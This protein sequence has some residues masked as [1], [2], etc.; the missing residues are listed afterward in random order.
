MAFDHVT[1][2]V[3]GF[4]N[5]LCKWCKTGRRNRIC[6]PEKRFLSYD[7]AKEGISFLAERR[8]I[9]R[10]S[11][12]D[13]FSWGEPFL[14]PQ[15]NDIIGLL[16]ENEMRI[17]LSTNASKYVTIPPEYLPQIEY[18]IISIS[19][20]SQGTYGRIHGLN[21]DAILKNVEKYA[22]HFR[23]HG[24][25]SKIIM[26]YHVYQYNIHEIRAASR[27]CN[28]Q[29]IIFSPHIAYLA[30]EEL[31]LPY[32]THTMEPSLL[33]EASEE[34]LFGM[35]RNLEDM[36]PDEIVCPQWDNLVLDERLNVLPCCLF[37]TASNIGSI[38][39]FETSEEIRLLLKENEYCKECMRSKQ[40]QIVTSPMAFPYG[41]T[42]EAVIIPKVY[43]GGADG[44]FSEEKTMQCGPIQNGDI[45]QLRLSIGLDNRIIR[46]DPLENKRCIIESIRFYAGGEDLPIIS[47]NGT[48]REGM[49]WF[50]NPDPQLVVDTSGRDGSSDEIIIEGKCI[51][52]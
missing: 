23:N 3:S 13:L 29:R 25:S 51:W 27:F 39:D 16:C 48:A 7:E 44:S 1:M 28:A 31:F 26:N 49:Y 8:I 47:T 45:F 41:Y 38:Y 17:G 37:T 12:F 6:T 11:L 52:Y 15:I 21:F 43:L 9:N 18:L 32:L 20:F 24:C 46:F 22:E 5:A 35:I 33:E 50:D 10:H 34:I 14:N 36:L 19:G 4:C 42:N 40:A 2:E 30:D